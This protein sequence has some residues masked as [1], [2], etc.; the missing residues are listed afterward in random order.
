MKKLLLSSLCGLAA[1][2]SLY[3]ANA[4]ATTAQVDLQSYMDGISFEQNDTS[5][6]ANKFRLSL[7]NIE[8]TEIKEG[9]NTVQVKL[10]DLD[11]K[12]HAA[13]LCN[14]NVD[15]SKEK[16][17][18]TRFLSCTGENSQ[19]GYQYIDMSPRAYKMN[20]Y[21][22][23]ELFQSYEFALEKSEFVKNTKDLKVASL[24]DD[25]VSIGEAQLDIW[26]D[27]SLELIK[28]SPN[29]LD[30]AAGGTG[31]TFH[32][33][34]GDKVIGE[35]RGSMSSYPGRLK[36]TRVSFTKPHDER[37]ARLAITKLEDG[38]YHILAYK[39]ERIPVESYS[40][41][42]KG[43][44]VVKT[45]RQ[46]SSGVDSIYSDKGKNWFAK[47]TDDLDKLANSAIYPEDP[48][49]IR[50]R[51]QEKE[52]LAKK[53][54]EK[55][56]REKRAKEAAERKEQQRIAREE[57]IA[58]REQAKR[59][60][61]Q[62][63]EQERLEREQLKAEQKAEREA[64]QARAREQSLEAQAK[65]QAS[66]EEALQANSGSVGFSFNQLL[67]SLVLMSSG[68]L[69]AKNR[70][71]SKVP[72]IGQTI[73]AMESKSIYIGYAVIGLGLFDFFT[74]L[75]SFSPIV[76]NGLVQVAALVS[77]VLLLKNESKLNQINIFSKVKNAVL[78]YEELMGLTAITLG[79]L[80]LLLGGL[81]LI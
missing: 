20:F 7:G 25:Y 52:R 66:R 31:L 11:G 28:P 46:L 73:A 19:H 57:A 45:G 2:S 47:S 30:K 16:P 77:G 69:V 48:E 72:Q 33:I 13:W 51:E 21:N 44:K 4:L 8:V 14:T 22:K 39:D 10:L 41:E 78:P 75:I 35:G 76:G 60:A 67:L 6:N 70:V 68:L 34:R 79:I 15:Y 3:N 54:K 9:K 37:G 29:T 42:V 53:A 55:A 27:S 24:W 17:G 64:Q 36:F 23:G 50:K 40:F 18:N 71:L 49:E 74:D 38:E 26:Q 65:G 56:E 1:F 5:T 43:G 62:K 12:K 58:K 32:L 61:K 59:E 63:K 80:H 81:P